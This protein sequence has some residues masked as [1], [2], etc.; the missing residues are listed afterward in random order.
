[1][2]KVRIQQQPI[3]KPPDSPGPSEQL[4]GLGPRL[5]LS[6]P[7]LTNIYLDVSVD[8]AKFFSMQK[9]LQSIQNVC[10]LLDE[11]PNTSNQLFGG[12][13][14]AVSTMPKLKALC[15]FNE[16]DSVACVINYRVEC[17]GFEVVVH[18]SWPFEVRS[19]T[20]AYWRKVGGHPSDQSWL[21][22]Q[23]SYDAVKREIIS[24]QQWHSSLY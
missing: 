20:K 5:I 10:A 8:V 15:V 4:P 13:G 1:M 16:N 14:R 11:V 6:C 23:N 19:A 2:D 17:K 21:L 7:F 9:Y 22:L 3:S 18:C 24:Q 12:F